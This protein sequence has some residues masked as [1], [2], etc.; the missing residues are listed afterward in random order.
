MQATGQYSL[1]CRIEP[2]GELVERWVLVL[3]QPRIQLLKDL[4]G[5]LLGDPSDPGS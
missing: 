2:V 1:H 3:V 4:L 5:L